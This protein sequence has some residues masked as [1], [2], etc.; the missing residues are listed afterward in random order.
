MRWLEG[1]V[2]RPSTGLSAGRSRGALAI[3]SP[4]FLPSVTTDLLGASQP[5]FLGVSFLFC[6]GDHRSCPVAFFTGSA[7]VRIK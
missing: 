4:G 5:L 1:R 3:R 6:Q 2:P 7:V